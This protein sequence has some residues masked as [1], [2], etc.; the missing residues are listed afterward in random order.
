MKL[1][2]SQ[3]KW[4]SRLVAGRQERPYPDHFRSFERVMDRLMAQGLARPYVHGGWE[5]TELGREV[6]KKL[7]V[8]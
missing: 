3:Q 6:A 8:T 5:V 7:S 1:S 2:P 4:L